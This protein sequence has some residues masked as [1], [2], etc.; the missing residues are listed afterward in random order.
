MP[1]AFFQ[2]GC[3]SLFFPSLNIPS[4]RLQLTSTSV[5]LF[6]YF[7]RFPF[8][9]FPLPPLDIFFSLF[10]LFFF[11]LF[12]L[13]SYFSSSSLVFTHVPHV[14]FFSVFSLSLSFFRLQS[15]FFSFPSILFSSSPLIRFL[16]VFLF[17]SFFP[18]CFFSTVFLSHLPS[19]TAEF[20]VFW[21]S[22][23]QCYIKFNTAYINHHYSPCI[24]TKNPV[25]F[26]Q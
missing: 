1:I 10:F 7:P 14:Y 4:Q 9:S 6:L 3:V 19:F 21:H 24:T 23:D 26:I 17:R 5:S 11:H 12:E 13:F 8:P 18:P 22:H 16:S 15:S 2:D 20:Q 25:T